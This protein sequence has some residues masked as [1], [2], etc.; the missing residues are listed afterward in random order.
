MEDK[1]YG[2]D[3]TKDWDYDETCNFRQNSG[4]CSYA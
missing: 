1:H 2:Q 4:A 3:E